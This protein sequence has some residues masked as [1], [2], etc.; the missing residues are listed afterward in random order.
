MLV[1]V[2]TSEILVAY[3]KENNPVVLGNIRLVNE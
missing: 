2:S 3:K 1:L